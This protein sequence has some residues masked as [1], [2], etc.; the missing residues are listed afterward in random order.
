MFKISNY[1][2]KARQGVISINGN[3]L[4]TPA[5]IPVMAFYCGASEKNAFGGGIYKYLKMHLNEFDAVLGNVTHF[6]DFHYT[7]QKVK[8]VMQ[9]TIK[10]WFGFKGLLFIDSGGYKFLTLKTKQTES[11]K[12][13]GYGGFSLEASPETILEYQVSMGADVAMTLDFPI[14]QQE[15]QDEIR[16]RIKKSSDY[17]NKAKSIAE[18]NGY[19]IKIYAAVHGHN[20]NDITYCL[21]NICDG[22]DGYAIGSLVPLKN[23]YK[24]LVDIVSSVRKVIP[25]EKP[26]HVFGI[27]GSMIPILAF[28]GADTFDSATYVHAGRFGQYFLPNLKRVNIKKLSDLN[29]DCPICKNHEIEEL[30]QKGSKSASLIAMH[31][32]YTIKIITENVRNAIISNELENTIYNIFSNN[33]K[34]LSAFEYAKLK[35]DN[36][37]K[38]L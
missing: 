20:A 35:I 33:N 26:L 13:I 25:P 24:K 18:E 2:G 27:T 7:E 3:I 16:R 38:M 29:C 21:E 15:D 6:L 31:N 8:Y 32:Y 5:V 30:R 1:D 28:L 12:L 22:F 19:N 11:N 4:K 34:L 37:N 23:N 9:K 14:G 17:A 10:D 36:D